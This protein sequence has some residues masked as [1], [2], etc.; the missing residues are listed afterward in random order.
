[1]TVSSYFVFEQKDPKRIM[2]HF[3][4]RLDDAAR[5]AEARSML[6]VI[7]LRH[8]ALRKCHLKPT[9]AQLPK[10]PAEARSPLHWSPSS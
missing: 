3:V 1:M 2:R 4:F 9:P 6:K 7:K 5:I 10:S 8:P